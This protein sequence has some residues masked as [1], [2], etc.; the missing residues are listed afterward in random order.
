MRLSG[1]AVFQCP[2]DA[3]ADFLAE[4]GWPVWRYEF[5]IGEDGGLTWHANEIGY[6]FQHTAIGSGA[7]MQ[8]YWAA[9]A[10]TGDPNGQIE[11]GMARPHWEHWDPDAPRQIRFTIADTVMEP[12]KPGSEV[13]ALRPTS[14]PDPDSPE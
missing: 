14:Q 6:V 2:T 12:G 5:D 1:D 13:C 8:D 7:H 3:L 9:L 11:K 4:Q 10:L